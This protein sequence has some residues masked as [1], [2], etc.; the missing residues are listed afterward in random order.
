MGDQSALLITLLPALIFALVALFEIARPRRT[1]R[2]GRVARWRT[3]L[4]L[5][6]TGRAALWF[7]AWIVA[8][9]A[10]AIWAGSRGIGAFNVMELPLWAEI[11]ASF[12]LF[13]FAM[14]LQHLLTHKVPVLW[15]LHIVHH[16]DPDMDVSTAIRFHPGEIMFSVFWKASWVL[17]L[18]VS[19]PIIIAFE[20]W[21]AANALFNHGNLELP[22]RMDRFLRRF[23]V[24]PDMH[25]VHHGVL[26]P[27]Q[28]SNYGFALTLWDRLFQTYRIESSQGRENQAVGLIDLQDSRAT[29]IGYSLKLPV[30]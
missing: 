2:F 23:L 20:I 19:A 9:P 17:L 4:L 16:A 13:D 27:E 29:E 24:T 6:V 12:V 3:G 30:T 21:L 18:G 26:V 14:W 8:V 11:L 10:V 22:R 5:A 15:R 1:L 7:L 25:L 28:Q